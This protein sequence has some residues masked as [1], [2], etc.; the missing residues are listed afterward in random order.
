[1]NNEVTLAQLAEEMV[2]LRRQVEQ[3]NQRLDM[4]YGAVTRL[5]EAGRE[6]PPPEA[7]RPGP[8]PASSG[9]NG[10]ARPASATSMPL[11]AD[12]MMN[13]GGMLESLRQYAVRAGLEISPQSVDRLKTNLPGE[14]AQDDS[15]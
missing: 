5:A 3:V 15:K 2:Q 7:D 8:L 9:G 4:I 6:G 1:M 10:K 11:S 14:E 13:P 12:M